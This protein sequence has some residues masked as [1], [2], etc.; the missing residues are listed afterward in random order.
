M[1]STVYFIPVADNEAQESVCGKIGQLMDS[2]GYSN[3]FKGGDHVLV[4]LHF[5]EEGNIGYIK[6]P[7][8]KSVV[9]RL[10]Q[11]QARPFLADTTTL[12]VGQRSN[13]RDHLLIADKHGFS[14]RDIGC[15]V[16]IADGL[17]GQNQ[18]QVAINGKHFQKT[19]IASDAVF[20]QSI[21]ALSHITGH[22]AAGI[23]GS[24]KN[25]GMG[26]AGRGGKLAQHY[27]EMPLIHKERC[28]ACS[29]C[30]EWCPEQAITVDG[31]IT[32]NESAC[33]GCGGCLA[34]CP[35]AA[36]G[37]NWKAG[38]S[39]QERVAEYAAGALKDKEGKCFFMNFIMHTTPNC[40]CIG[41]GEEKI[42]PD[43]GIIASSD[44]VAADAAA[45]DIIK[46]SCG[47]DLFQKC[48]PGIDYTVI[49]KHAEFMGLGFR[50][51]TLQKLM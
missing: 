26:L 11:K 29:I 12:Y 16:I 45:I 40:D 42:I 35:E 22:L 2:A 13:A 21:F 31:A 33:I 50:K 9:S 17:R 20:S 51:Y 5:G 44:I 25:V 46:E 41:A 14:I 28:T 24:I 1:S 4:K 36:I 15:P 18:V 34:V 8:V 38:C 3:Y 49:L 30:E 10:L 23:G 27:N 19:H 39:L 47:Y 6:P 48:W 43:I 32:I 37:F 7:L